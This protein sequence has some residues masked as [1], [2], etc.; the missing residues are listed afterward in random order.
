MLRPNQ[1]SAAVYTGSKCAERWHTR[2]QGLLPPLLEVLLTLPLGLLIAWSEEWATATMGSTFLSNTSLTLLCNCVSWIVNLTCRSAN[3]HR[4]GRDSSYTNSWVF[5]VAE[6]MNCHSKHT[7][8]VRP[9]TLSTALPLLQ[10]CLRSHAVC[11][12]LSNGLSTCRCVRA[13]S[14]KAASQHDGLQPRI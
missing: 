10:P 7:A 5:S 2:L 14:C 6:C 11:R 9:E 1:A 8:G 3:R 12:P 4:H 13:G